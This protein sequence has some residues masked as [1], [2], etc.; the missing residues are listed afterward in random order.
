[1]VD[2]RSRCGSMPRISGRASSDEA[3]AQPSAPSNM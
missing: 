2:W 3:I 1:M